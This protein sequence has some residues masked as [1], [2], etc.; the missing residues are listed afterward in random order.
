MNILITGITGF[1]GTNL[2]HYLERQDQNKINFYA[3]TRDKSRLKK[4][5]VNDKISAF[6]K[7][8]REI[9]DEHKIEVII[10]LAG[11]AHDLS[12]GYKEEDYEDVNYGLTKYLYN[13]FLKSYHTKKF[14]YLSSVK[15]LTDKVDT[16]LTEK[17]IPSPK[18]PYGK[19]KLRAEQYILNT[20]RNDKDAYI[21]RPSMVYGSGN[22][23]NLNLLYHLIKKGYPYPLGAFTNS[24]SFLSV[25]NL[26]FI[27]WQMIFNTIP[28]GDYNCADGTDLSTVELVELIG[29]TINK[30]ARILKIN[31]AL[32]IPT[33][34]IGTLLGIPFNQATLKKLTEN[35]QVSSN[36]LLNAL[37]LEK[38]PYDTM[39]ELAKTIKSFDSP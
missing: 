17:Q 32:M 37:G 4:Q 23:G 26:S 21:L 18:T 34:K 7:I 28:K 22:K 12:G 11:I 39:S 36:K 13:E 25:N 31:K 8:D 29:R 30:P 2:Y 16:I 15:A 9:L 10:H 27:I 20:I 1:I 19:S 5:F 14:I 24:R 35:Y 6:T 33:A 3:L 38:M